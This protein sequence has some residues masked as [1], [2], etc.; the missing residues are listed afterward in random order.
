M[1]DEATTSAPPA[2]IIIKRIKKGGHGHHGGAWKVAYADFVTAMMA[3]FLLL[4]L[5]N[6]TSPEQRMG[7]AEYFT[8]TI[9]IKDS[10]GIG[11]QGGKIPSNKPGR[12]TQN[13][14]A[15]GLVVGQIK[16]GPVAQSPDVPV[17]R[18]D[19]T[20]ENTSTNRKANEEAQ[21]AADTTDEETFKTTA[22]EVRQALEQDPDIESYR[23]NVIVNDTP[24]GL[25]IDIIDDRKKPMFIPGTA[26]ITDMGKKII[27]SMSSI[28]IKTP[29]NIT[30]KGHTDAAGATAN[31]QYTSWELSADRANAARRFLITTQLE[32]ERIMKVVGMA[33]R[34]LLTPEEPA[35]PR[36]RRVTIILMRGSY[37]RDPKSEAA[38]RSLISVSEPSPEPVKPEPVPEPEPPPISGT[39]IF[40][41]A[42]P[43]AEPVVV[44]KEQGT[45]NEVRP[46]LHLPT[47]RPAS[48]KKA[49]K[50]EAPVVDKKAASTGIFDP[51]AAPTQPAI[52]LRESQSPVDARPELHLPTPKGPAEKKKIEPKK[53]E[54][55]P[56]SNNLEG[57]IFDPAAPADAN[58]LKLRLQQRD[59]R[60]ELNLKP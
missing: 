44:P 3:F 50:Q 57:S 41:P 49:Q 39:S 25:K 52:R 47:P 58:L 15:P 31:P 42:A 24:E 53:A 1:A 35:N 12:S 7:L 4:W 16:Q 26:N 36:N 11:F 23:N 40:N 32:P 9:G 33:D 59:E 6:V 21:D 5:I 56:K 29:N 18:P 48:E 55:V 27:D 14:A 38:T 19:P 54:P 8:P 37:F 60:P 22:E 2:P 51:A 13:T 34:E 45:P 30:I 20:A 43:A 10:M 28:I 17:A 46:E